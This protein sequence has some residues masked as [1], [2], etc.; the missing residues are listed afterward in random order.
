[1]NALVVKAMMIPRVTVVR[2]LGRG[3]RRGRNHAGVKASTTHSGIVLRRRRVNHH[4]APIV[5][6]VIVVDHVPLLLVET[7]IGCAVTV[8]CH[9]P[10]IVG[11]L[12]RILWMSRVSSRSRFAQM[13]KLLVRVQKFS[14]FDHAATGKYAEDLS[15]MLGEL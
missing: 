10:S 2:H 7:S 5:K 13:S 9:R 8:T 11:E 15:L 14:Q 6:T 1:M 3:R 12:V 4:F